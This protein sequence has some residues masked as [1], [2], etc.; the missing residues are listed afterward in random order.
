MSKYRCWTKWVAGSGLCESSSRM[1]FHFG[2]RVL[3][4]GAIGGG[5]AGVRGG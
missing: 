2:E 1:A 5:D 3:V 4:V